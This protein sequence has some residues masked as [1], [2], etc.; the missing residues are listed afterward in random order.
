V[1]T[2][3][4]GNPA[5]VERSRAAELGPAIHQH[6]SSRADQRVWLERLPDEA[7]TMDL[8]SFCLDC[9]AIRSKAVARGR[10]FGF[11]ERWLVN[12]TVILENHPK[13]AKLVQVHR[14]LMLRAIEATRDFGDPYSMPFETQRHLFVLSV[15]RVRG[16]LPIEFIEE[17]MPRPPRRSR[18]AFMDLIPTIQDQEGGSERKAALG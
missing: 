16:D 7:A 15:Q 5:A 17:G 12:L 14:R 6:R 13:Y 3:A 18:P 4:G 2:L 9:G 1:A 8:H 11:F 10:P